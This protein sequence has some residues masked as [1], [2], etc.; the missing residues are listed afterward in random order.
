MLRL[1]DT[2]NRE[3]PTDPHLLHPRKVPAYPMCNKHQGIRTSLRVGTREAAI[4]CN[5][6]ERSRKR[7]RK[8]SKPNNP[9][10]NLRQFRLGANLTVAELQGCQFTEVVQYL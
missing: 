2:T 7:K 10:D 5:L 8:Q 6:F 1:Y 9:L 4:N 3:T